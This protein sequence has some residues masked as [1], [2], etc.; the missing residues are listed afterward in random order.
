MLIDKTIGFIGAGNMAETL[1]GGLIN[2]GQSS[3]QEPDLL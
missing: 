2:S 3:P 1:I